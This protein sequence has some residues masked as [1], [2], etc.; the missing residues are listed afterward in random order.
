MTDR[1]NKGSAGQGRRPVERD[2]V[3]LVRVSL[4]DEVPASVQGVRAV[5]AGRR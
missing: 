5:E 1:P 4:L 2:P 3:R